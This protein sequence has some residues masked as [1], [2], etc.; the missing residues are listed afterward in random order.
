[1]DSV[2]SIEPFKIGKLSE[3][4]V[5][6]ELFALAG[7]GRRGVLDSNHRGRYCEDNPEVALAGTIYVE[8]DMTMR[9]VF[10][11]K[12]HSLDSVSLCPN[13]PFFDHLSPYDQ[14]PQTTFLESSPL[15]GDS[16]GPL[17]SPKEHTISGVCSQG[18]ANFL[19]EGEDFSPAYLGLSFLI[20]HLC[21]TSDGM[22]RTICPSLTTRF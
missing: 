1:M 2:P 18:S 17:Y 14:L 12:I 19:C 22:V 15:P 4:S 11:C 9:A 8:S 20:R 13:E 21:Q 5:E 16:G 3:P 7:F 10:F 6:K